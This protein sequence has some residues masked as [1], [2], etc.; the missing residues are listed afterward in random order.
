MAS[1]SSAHQQV[2]DHLSSGDFYS[3]HQKAR[4]TATRLL[5]PPRRNPPPAGTVLPYDTKAQEAAETLWDAARKLLENG[6]QGSGVDLA[7]M[8]VQ[9]VWTARDVGCD[10]EERAKIIQLIALTGR[11]GAWR[12]TLTD[13][14]FAWTSKT[15]S[16]PAGD[17]EIHEYLG[18]TLYKELDYEQ[19]SLHLLVCPTQDAARTLANVL[20]DWHKLDPDSPPESSVGRYAARGV[21]SYLEASFILAARTFLSHFMALAL[22]AYPALRVVAFPYPPP[23][24]ALAKSST[25]SASPSADELT[26]TKLASL[27]FL[28]L[29]IQAVQAGVGE[30]VDRVKVGNEMRVQ[31][32]AGTKAWQSLVSRYEKQVQWLRIPEVKEATTAIGEIHFGIRPARQGNP[33]MDM[34]ASMFGGGGGGGGG[35]SGAPALGAPR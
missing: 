14:V 10:K 18:E 30:S 13:A 28:Q 32:G 17:V 33:L 8:L 27:N 26:V 1:L 23:Q 11:S 2:L 15:G 24:S 31:R 35:G 34:M 25:A 21:L 19:A 9:D 7:T 6:Q 12:K 29:A 16:G 5:A 22:A 3:A 20:F 4:T